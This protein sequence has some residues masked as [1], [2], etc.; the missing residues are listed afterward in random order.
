MPLIDKM[1]VRKRAII[2]TINDQLKN[3]S[4]IAHMQ[5]R[6]FNDFLMNLVAGQIAYTYRAKKPSLN[7]STEDLALLSALF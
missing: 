1:L 3:I 2:E 7:S 5:L 4:Q 6:R